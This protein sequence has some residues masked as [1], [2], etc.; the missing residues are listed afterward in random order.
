MGGRVAAEE[1]FGERMRKA[2]VVAEGSRKAPEA[3]TAAASTV[4]IGH[5]EDAEGE[6]ELAYAGG[7]NRLGEVAA[8][9]RAHRS[10]RIPT[11]RRRAGRR[12]QG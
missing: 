12:S 1:W 9:R 2:V 7:S 11:Y 10:P 3:Q 6:E 8:D 4:D 5:M